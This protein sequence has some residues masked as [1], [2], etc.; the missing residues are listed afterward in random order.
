[1]AEER[2]REGTIYISEDHQVKVIMLPPDGEE[3]VN[4]R[5]RT[6]LDL[7]IAIGRRQGKIRSNIGNSKVDAEKAKE[8]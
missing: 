7:A 1:M 5:I 6:I 3:A 4:R 2:P 8:E